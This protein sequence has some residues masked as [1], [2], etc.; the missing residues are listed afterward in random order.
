M[1][2]TFEC[3]HVGGKQCEAILLDKYSRVGVFLRK[4]LPLHVCRIPWLAG[5]YPVET[6]PGS[7]S[8]PCLCLQTDFE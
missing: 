5:N 2:W 6:C 3:G 1:S 4:C 7:P 8:A